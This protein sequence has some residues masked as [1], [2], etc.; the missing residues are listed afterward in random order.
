MLL[1]SHTHATG[2][3][4]TPNGLVRD[5]PQCSTD[6][7]EAFTDNKRHVTI[8]REYPRRLDMDYPLFNLLANEVLH[9]QD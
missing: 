9:S 8:T 6:V 5:Y 4:D 2:A 7:D 3:T 1:L